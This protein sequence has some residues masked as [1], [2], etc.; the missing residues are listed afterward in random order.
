[1][2]K[3]ENS[4]ENEKIYTNFCGT[5]PTYPARGE[6]LFCARGKS[7]TSKKET[8]CNCGVCDVW[9]KNGLKDFYYCIKGSAE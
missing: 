8:G 9:N 1:M 2:S 7:S 4:L 6:F 3:V 5:C